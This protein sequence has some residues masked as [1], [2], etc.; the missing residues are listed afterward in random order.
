MLQLWRMRKHFAGECPSGNT[1]LIQIKKRDQRDQSTGT[2]EIGA[3][4]SVEPVTHIL[5]EIA[6][7]KEGKDLQ[8]DNMT[9]RNEEENINTET[10]EK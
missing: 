8:G 5:P 1:P 6:Q 7:K 3:A 10:E 9:G 2:E 4:I